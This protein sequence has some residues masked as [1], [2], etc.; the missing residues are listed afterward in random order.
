MTN[1][2]QL[3]ALMQAAGVIYKMTH[4]SAEQRAFLLQKLKE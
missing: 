2:E 4:L 1:S 3:H